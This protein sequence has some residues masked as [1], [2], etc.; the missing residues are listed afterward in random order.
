L[1]VHTLLQSL[2]RFKKAGYQTV[3]SSPEVAGVD[4]QYAVSPAYQYNDG[5]R[6]ARINFLTTLG[7]FF[8]N[9]RNLYGRHA[10]HGAIAAVLVPI[11]YL[12]GFAT[13]IVLFPRQYVV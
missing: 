2:A 5:R 4:Q 11:Q 13:H 1:A 10:A 8:S 12:E 3:E 7:A 6:D 9:W